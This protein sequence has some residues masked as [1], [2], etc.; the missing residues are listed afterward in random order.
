ME[1]LNLDVLREEQWQDTFC[2]KKVKILRMKQDDSF[3]LDKNSILWNMVRLKYTKEP[4]IV[5]PRKLTSLTIVEFHNGK[6]HK[7]ISCTV[8]MIRHYFWWVGIC[9]DIHQHI[10]NCQLYIQF[11]PNWLYT[12]AMHI[13]IPKV[14]FA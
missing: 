5:L 3:V 11:L 10:S 9:R 8:N 1:K 12:Q 14:P 6:G 13:D 7:S 4:T 2:M